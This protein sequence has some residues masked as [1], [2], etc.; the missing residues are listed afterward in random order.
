MIRRFILIYIGTICSVVAGLGQ[1]KDSIYLY[2]GQILI[3]E[4]RG[5]NF[6]SITIDDMDLKMQSVKLFK[7]RRLRI[8]EM[9]KI[10]TLDKHLY[11]G[12]LE[13]SQKPGW[14]VI[15][16][17]REPAEEIPIVDIYQ[18]IALN[19]E[20]FKRLEGSLSAGFSY[21]RSSDIG[22]V[23]FNSTVG[24]ATRHFNY[25]LQGSEIGSIDSSHFSRDNE[26]LQLFAGY[27]LS[28]VWFVAGVGQYQ[29]NLELSIARRW[30]QMAGGGKKLV[31]KD[32]WQ[33][34]V[35]SGLTF[36]QEKSTE[37]VSSGLLL[38]L[39]IMFQFNFFK[40]H[41][42]DIQIASTQTAYFS[43]SEKGRIRYD[44]NTSFSWQLIRYFYLTL[45]P[46]ASFDSKPPSQTGE[47]FDY[48]IAVSLSYKF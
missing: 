29:R 45:G 47:K 14:I 8:R 2:N 26:N 19:G 23:N 4:I 30:L 16:P 40:F 3:G 17:D 11:F 38:E 32:T 1:N 43:L 46:Y 12:L 18:L 7:I 34:L 13:V 5:A 24:F 31:V 44:S 36:T 10:E 28:A 41:H 39:P 37:G 27:N 42:P 6:G 25:Q 20:F 48:G 9:F 35:V 22:Q 33:L 21:A 15:R